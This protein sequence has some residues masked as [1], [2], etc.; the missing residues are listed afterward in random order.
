MEIE[1]HTENLN[2]ICFQPKIAKGIFNNTKNILKVI[3]VI[4]SNIIEIP[5]TPPSITWLGIKNNSNPIEARIA[6]IVTKKYFFVS[7][8]AF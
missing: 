1:P 8:G 5:T 4:C 2:P 6:P 3:P 7:S